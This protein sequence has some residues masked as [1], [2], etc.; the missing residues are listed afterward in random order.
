[1]TTN[2]ISGVWLDAQKQLHATGV[3]GTFLIEY[4]RDGTYSD[5]VQPLG[6]EVV[7]VLA[8]DTQLLTASMGERL[9][10]ADSY[11][12]SADGINGVIPDTSRSDTSVVLVYGQD[13]PKKNW[14]FPLRRTWMDPWSLLI[15]WK[16]TGLMGVQWPY[17]VDWYSVDWPAHP[18][19]FVLGENL[20]RGRASALIPTELTAKLLSDMDPPLSA[21]L[22]D[23][24]KSFTHLFP[25]YAMIQ[26]QNQTNIWFDVI[27]AVS[28]TNAAVFDL[29]PVPV[30]IG[31]E[32]TPGDENA[33]A[34]WFD[35]D[36]DYV[37]NGDAYFNKL[38]QWTLSFWFS[39]DKLQNATLYSEG[40]TNQADLNVN[41]TTNGQVQ[42][43]ARNSASGQ[44]VTFTTT[45]AP[46]RSN[47]WQY[48]TVAFNDVTP[49]AGRLEVYLDDDVESTNAMP[50]VQFGGE[51][52]S[53]W[54][55]E[56]VSPITNFYR[57][58]LDELRLWSAALDGDQIS[59]NRFNTTPEPQDNLI[60]WFPC[61]EGQ[62]YVVNNYGGDKKGTVYGNATWTYGQTIPV[63]DWV[64]YAGYIHPAEGTRYNVEHYNY[65]TEANPDNESHVFAVNTGELEVWW[66]NQSRNTDMPPVYYPSRVTRY[67][68]SWPSNPSQIVIAS[69]LGS[70]GEQ[71]EGSE[72]W[73]PSPGPGSRDLLSERFQPGRLQSQ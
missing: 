12:G 59:S 71:P 25:G 53:I 27:R 61:D 9:L 33:H 18:Q 62:G 2:I 4:Y 40:T 64:G 44:L 72:N 26:Y 48:L 50:R 19:L 28:H 31:K 42:V 5:Q 23:S 10:P 43:Q 20:D 8:P 68:N 46:V 14:A 15:Y 51:D 63:D 32:L 49:G 52:Q 17:E 37:A 65:P 7:R 3:T 47:T 1:M 30:E 13:G 11:W 55:A 6:V 35:A 22:S 66:A 69:G 16:Q 38:A 54:A 57:G 67:T 56:S 36:G 70:N 39:A 73:D 41:L 24:G 34:L 45:N 29:Q 60:A 58:K 21:R